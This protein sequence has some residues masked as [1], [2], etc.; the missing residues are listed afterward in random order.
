MD[1]NCHV[2]CVCCGQGFPNGMAQ[3]SRIRMVGKALV[4][5]GCRFSVFNI[6]AGPCPNPA[7]RGTVDGIHF[8][9]L[10]GPTLRP[11]GFWKRNWMYA[12]GLLQACRRLYALRSK[13]TNLCVYLYFAGWRFPLF[14][15]FLRAIRLPIIQEVGEWWPGAR[16]RLIRDRSLRVSQGTLAISRHVIDRLKALPSYTRDHRILHVPILIDTDEWTPRARAHSAPNGD[17]PYILWCG[18]IGLSDE[19]IQFLLRVTKVVNN[20][21][22]CRGVLVGRHEDSSRDRIYELART[23]G[24]RM[25]LLALPGFVSDDELNGL[26]SG[27]TALLL[28]LWETERSISRFPTKLAHYLASET[29]VVT[30]GVGDL[31]LYLEDGQSACLVPPG[32]VKEFA[33]KVTFLIRNPARAK[34]I[35]REGRL[36]AMEHFSIKANRAKLAQFFAEVAR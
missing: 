5:E 18:N 21:D 3:A 11:D 16:E 7:S 36:V 8:E 13:E 28:P 29:P 34:M 6:G 24:L 17:I 1:S 25:D 20:S 26:M 27:A 9:Y 33:G 15:R 10:P 35:G 19:D 31:T 32:D 23:L 4:T 12:R 14:H 22:A 2:I 30:T